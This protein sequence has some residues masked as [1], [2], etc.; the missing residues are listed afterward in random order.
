MPPSDVE[1]ESM[2]DDLDPDFKI[3]TTDSSDELSSKF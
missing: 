2:D 3:A 1:V